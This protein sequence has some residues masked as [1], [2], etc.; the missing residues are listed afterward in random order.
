MKKYLIFGIIFI[1]ASFATA[2]NVSAASISS[3]SADVVVGEVDQIDIN[4]EN[5]DADAP[6]TG[7][8]G[9]NSDSV[10]IV[11]ATAFLT[12]PIAVILACLLIHFHRKYTK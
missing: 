9:P 12:I 3:Q 4:N 5:P 1:M 11:V 2:A 6:N 10:T 7:L 8:F